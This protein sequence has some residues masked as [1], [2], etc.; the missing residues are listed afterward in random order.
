MLNKL[1]IGM[2]ETPV[3]LSG[4]GHLMVPKHLRKELGVQEG[5]YFIPEIDGKNIVFRPA[6]VLK[7]EAFKKAV[8]LV[9]QKGL[10][11]EELDEAIAWAKKQ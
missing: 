2:S 10:T 1:T 11:Q 4:K 9:A 8:E 3:K 5:E 6:Q 7:Q